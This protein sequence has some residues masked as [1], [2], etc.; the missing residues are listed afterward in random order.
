MLSGVPV[1]DVHILSKF[2]SEGFLDQ[3]VIVYPD[4]PKEVGKQIRFYDRPDDA[5]MAIESYLQNP[6]QV[7]TM[8]PL[9]RQ[10]I[11]PVF[12]LAGEL[13]TMIS[14]QAVLST[15]IAPVSARSEPVPTPP[16]NS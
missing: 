4:R 5:E 3:L 11:R 9:V 15:T 2:F 14:S 13:T 7:G 8:L 10:E 16:T 1:V 12:R 6:P